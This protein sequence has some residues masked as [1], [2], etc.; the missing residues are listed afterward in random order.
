MSSRI[1][2]NAAIT[3]L[4]TFSSR[5]LGLVRQ[6]VIN[7]LFPPLLTDAF[8]IAT[9]VPN[10][11]RELVAE[12]AVTNALVPVLSGLPAAEGEVFKRRFA[13]LLLTLNLLL[14]G[15]GLLLAPAVA[16]WL[17]DASS[18]YA[19]GPNFDLLVYQ[20]RLVMP[21]LLFI[22]MAA[23]FSA[24]LQSQER[25][26]AVAFA[27]LALNAVSIALM[28]VWPGSAT[29]LALSY[30]LGAMVQAAV[31][32][33]SLRGFGL[34]FRSH[35]AIRDA[36]WRMG[37][38]AFT[39]SLRQF[40]NLVLTNVLTRYAVGAQTAF[41]NAEVIFQT[42][43]GILAVSPA[44]ALYPRLTQMGAAQDYAGMR[45]LLERSIPRLAVLLG[46][47]GAMMVALAPWIVGAIFS[48][49]GLDARV[50]EFTVAV[51]LAYG[52]ALLPWGVNQ[53]M[54][55]AFYAANEIRRAVQVSV[56]IF[57]LNTLGYWL[58]RD[59]GLFWLNLSTAAAGLVGLLAYG[60]RLER[61]SILSLRWLLELLLRVAA[62]AAPAGMLAYVAARPFGTPAL[63][64]DNLPPLV[65]GGLAGLAA[66]VVFAR[67]LRLP[68]R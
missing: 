6:V 45:G 30:T 68:L 1:L 26:G 66:F 9:R 63:F 62:A 51:L 48:F 67:V 35:P 24:F 22:S 57:G 16:G 17:V 15:A 50:R 21:F 33:P 53:L 46:F 3:M 59:A 60:V 7:N 52:L 20:I 55:R 56:V 58:L 23:L 13:A 39:T 10:L 54:L 61:L 19:R 28:L 2:R 27:P 5:V 37:P 12:G 25:F 18:P 49:G 44:M 8:N 14:L 34:E 43:L 65:L 42:A 11:F 36:L 40:L 47:A 38:F 64:L 32:L 31:L 4:G 29:A 41:I